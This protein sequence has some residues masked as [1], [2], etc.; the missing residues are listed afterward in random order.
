MKEHIPYVGDRKARKAWNEVFSR[1]VLGSVILGSAT[2]KFVEYIITLT[3]LL[4]VGS[5]A[6]IIWRSFAQFVG[7]SVAI[8]I[9]IGVF[10]YW[11]RVEDKAEE[12]K[13]TADE[14]VEEKTDEN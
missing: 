6:P 1:E 7:W 8:P 11:H 10:V 13:E 12:V 9:G 3:V 4:F 2:G 5:D 14:I